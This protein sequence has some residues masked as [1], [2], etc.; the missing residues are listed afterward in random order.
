M[1]RYSAS[2]RSLSRSIATCALLALGLAAACEKKEPPPPETAAPER[3]SAS[4]ARPAEEENVALT[5]LSPDTPKTTLA[6]L[7]TPE[8]LEEE[9]ANTLAAD[10]LE[11]ELDRLEAEITT[12]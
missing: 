9:A 10:N 5:A 7:P 8:D 6:G 1:S 3:A 4:P 2:P 12:E 11:A